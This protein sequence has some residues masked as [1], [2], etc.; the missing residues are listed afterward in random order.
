MD[1]LLQ[2][3]QRADTRD[4][5]QVLHMTRYRA[6]REKVGFLMAILDPKGKA[7]VVKSFDVSASLAEF[8]FLLRNHNSNC[9]NDPSNDI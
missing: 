8:A 1:E 6:S 2:H 7:V 9:N 5:G 3:I 4:G